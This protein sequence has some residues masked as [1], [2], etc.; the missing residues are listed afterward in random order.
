[1][2]SQDLRRLC[3]DRLRRLNIR[4]PNPFD[5]EQ[6][7]AELARQRGRPIQIRPTLKAAAGKACGFWV[8]TDTMDVIVVEQGTTRQH[9][10]HII[11]HEIGHMVFDHYA[12]MADTT[13]AALA[14]HL[15]PELIR[16]VLGRTV[17][18]RREEQ[19]AEVFA[20][21]LMSKVSRSRETTSQKSPPSTSGLDRFASAVEPG[22]IWRG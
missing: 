22:G 5:A 8:G 2:A 18:T 15:D 11:A 16:R 6:L 17:Y 3:E 13:V 4:V 12:E 20:S 9:Q 19:E 1:M 14:S 10:D 21:V 7:C